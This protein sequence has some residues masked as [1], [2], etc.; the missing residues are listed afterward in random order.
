MAVRFVE[1]GGADGGD[2]RVNISN[3]QW[4]EKGHK[5]LTGDHAL[6]MFGRRSFFG[7]ERHR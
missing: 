2:A 7:L 6:I 4:I 5:D 3:V 1:F